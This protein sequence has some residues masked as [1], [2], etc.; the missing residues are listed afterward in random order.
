LNNV[1][2]SD[3]G[4][5]SVVVANP[6]GSVTSAVA[7]LTVNAAVCTN[8]PVGLVSWWAGEGNGSDVAGNNSA[9]VS[10]GVS[11]S[12]G[13][14]GQAFNFNGSSGS[15]F[16][17]ASSSL[18]VGTGSG[19]TIECWIK[20][21]DVSV[22]HPLFEWN[23]GT[24]NYGVHVY[25]SEDWF[26]NS[27]PGD[28]L[29]N[30]VDTAGNWHP[31]Y[32]APGLLSTSSFQHV[33]LTYDKVSGVGR[34]YLNGAVVASQ[35][36]GSFTPRTG[37]NLYVGRRPNDGGVALYGGLMDEVSIY[38]RALSQ[39]EVQ[40]IYVAGSAGKCTPGPSTVP[41]INLQGTKMLR[42]VPVSNGCQVNFVGIAG[43]QYVIQRAPSITGPWTTL[44]TI[45]VGSS[46]AGSYL[47]T[48]ALR[49]SAF[50][51]TVLQ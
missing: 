34:F 22:R 30:I 51:R 45:V 11:Y 40:G 28:L 5:Y 48:T 10:N 3:G 18:N 14:V 26:G 29:A 37:D 19:F 46:G 36:L 23:D 8:V 13:E 17:P 16:V 42:P 43:R 38:S 44:T 9:I 6:V 1:Q 33:A 39:V 4:N 7:V 35:N 31:L 15:M 2:L 27:G 25:H 21:S 50:Y 32:S 12:A 24:G 47:D 20:P 41:G 49:D